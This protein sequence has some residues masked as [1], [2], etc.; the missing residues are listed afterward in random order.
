MMFASQIFGNRQALL[1]H[2]DY[3]IEQRLRPYQ[4]AL[5]WFLSELFSGVLPS[6]WR[7]QMRSYLDDWDGAR[8]RSRR[9]APSD[10]RKRD[11]R[12]SQAARVDARFPAAFE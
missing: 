5:D 1:N 9:R 4:E 12:L 10:P 7:E 6:D 2:L 8:L 3:R 11:R